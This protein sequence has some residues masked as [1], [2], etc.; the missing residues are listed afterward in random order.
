[1]AVK[2]LP[3][4]ISALRF[5]LGNKKGFDDDFLREIQFAQERLEDDPTLEYWFLTKMAS[6][7]VI[8]GV[9]ELVLPTNFIREFDSILPFLQLNGKVIRLVRADFEDAKLHF[10][11]AVGQP[12]HYSEYDEKLVLF[13]TPDKGYILEYTYLAREEELVPT[14]NESNAWTRNAFQML[15]NKTGIALAQS[16]RDKEALANFTADFQAAFSELMTRITQREEV[17][18]HQSRGGDRDA[19]G[20]RNNG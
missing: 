11:N 4:L 20:N 17:N 8:S 3:K 6:I 13:P 9:A 19:L 12:T 5:R 1:M 14:T 2:T 18:F 16:F 7:I 10:Q 15:L